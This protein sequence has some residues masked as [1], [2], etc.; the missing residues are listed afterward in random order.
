MAFA[1]VLSSLDDEG[2]ADMVNR[3]PNNVR[4]QPAYF[5]EFDDVDFHARFRLS[6]ECVTEVLEAIEPEISHPTERNNAIS[7]INQLLLTLRFYATGSHLISAG[8]FS[9]VSKTSAHRVVHRVTNA[10][11][12]LRPRFIKFPTLADEIK[13]EQIKFF[14]IARFPRVVGCIDCT[15]IKIQSFGGNDAEYFR[16]RKGYFSINVQA[17]CNA[18]LQITDLVA[19]WQGSVHDTTIFNNSRIRTLFEAGTFGDALLLGDGGYPVRYYL[20]TPLRNTGTRAQEL[21]NE[22]LIRTRNTIERVFGIWKRRFPILALGTRFSKVE[23]VLPVIVATAIL[24]NIA[25]RAGD[26]LPPD[27]PALQL[28]WEE[29]LEQGNVP[30]M[31]NAPGNRVGMF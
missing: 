27:D 5:Y 24:H 28:P 7:A 13:T 15:H 14:D 22:S 30:L 31:N 4:R 21:Y 19:R 8:D 10:I 25:R 17:I 18:N 9:G 23:R 26:P 11:A 6:K 29:I 20:M 3:R 16:N 2:F 12:R 1:H